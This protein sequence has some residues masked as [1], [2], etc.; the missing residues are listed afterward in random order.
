MIDMAKDKA[1]DFWK[2]L[3]IMTLEWLADDAEIKRDKQA[4]GAIRLLIV[5]LRMDRG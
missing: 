2:E 3:L 4:A 1:D 5:L